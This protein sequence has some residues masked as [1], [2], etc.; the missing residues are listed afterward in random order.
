[1]RLDALDRHHFRKYSSPMATVIEIEKLA[2]DLPEK[3]RATL[4][5]NLLD[6][7]P[8]ILS[9]DDEGIAEALRR[10]AE[11]DAAPNRAISLAQL[12]VE[13]QKRRR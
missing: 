1:M 13:I 11:L 3:D 10:D 12:D 7:L 6:S 8:P 4:I 2:L 9:D 5:A